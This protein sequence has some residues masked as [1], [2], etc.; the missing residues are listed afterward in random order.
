MARTGCVDRDRVVGAV[1]M[2]PCR[3]AS[4]A[5]TRTTVIAVLVSGAE[6]VSALSEEV[7]GYATQPPR[8][9]LFYTLPELFPARAQELLPITIRPHVTQQ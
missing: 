1:S 2:G 3:G 6:G 4:E 8:A 9:G 5:D 7:R